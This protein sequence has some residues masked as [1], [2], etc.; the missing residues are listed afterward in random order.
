MC[1]FAGISNSIFFL[2]VTPLLTI[3]IRSKFNLLLKQF[4]SATAKQIFV[5]LKLYR[6]H[7]VNVHVRRKLWL[8]FSLGVTPLLHLSIWTKLNILLKLF[9]SASP[10]NHSTEFYE[11]LKLI[12]A[13]C[14]YVYLHRIYWFDFFS[15]STIRTMAKVY[16]FVQLVWNRFSMNGSEA[17]QSDIF[18]T[19][20]IPML[21]NCDNY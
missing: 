11:I 10:L 8:M 1:T 6:I 9:V 17:V 3:E 16:Y 18:L 12:R 19:V 20:N 4:V 13:C 2:G 15:V 21:P 14:V 5:K 7:C